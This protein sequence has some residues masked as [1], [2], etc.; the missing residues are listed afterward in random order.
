MHITEVPLFD[1]EIRGIDG[2]TK[3]GKILMGEA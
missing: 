1:L 3:L 2:L